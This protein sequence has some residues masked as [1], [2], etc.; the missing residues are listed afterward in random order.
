MKHNVI[1]VALFALVAVSV[2]AGSARAA[3]WQVKFD[4]ANLDGNPGE[5]NAGSF[6]M[7]VNDEWAPLGAARMR[8][9]VESGFF[10]GV[11]FF[12]VIDGFMAQFG[13]HGTPAVSAEWRAKVIKDDPVKESNKRGYVSFATSGANTRTTQ[14][15]INFDD[16]GNLDG[17]GF[18]PF[19]KI[20]SGM[21]VVDRI[22]KIGEKP[23]QGLIQ[24]RGNE[25]LKKDFPRLTYIK[26]A[27]IVDVDL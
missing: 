21:D 20:V 18:S 22:Y 27:T 16:N 23:N 5:A 13:I 15:F 10:T 6:A 24:Q 11:R 26:S 4:V 12:R 1:V 19:A 3:T 7:E 14:M 25:Y 9:L 17:M 2:S 8:E